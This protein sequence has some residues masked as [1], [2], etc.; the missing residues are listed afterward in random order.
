FKFIN[1]KNGHFAFVVGKVGGDW[2]LKTLRP[3]P[4]SY[5]QLGGNQSV[6]GSSL[7]TTVNVV[8]RAPASNIRYYHYTFLPKVPLVGSLFPTATTEVEQQLGTDR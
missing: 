4:I 2:N 3:N 8:L 1:G 7:S 5:A 6:P